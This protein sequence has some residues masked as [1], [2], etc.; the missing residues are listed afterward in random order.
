MAMIRR[1]GS[2]LAIVAAL[3]AP[4]NGQDYFARLGGPFSRVLVLNAPF[5]AEATTRVREVSP[6]GTARLHTVTA[7]YYRDSQGQV[8]AEVDTPWGPY[9]VVASQGPERVEFYA[10]DQTK[11]TYRIAAYG[12]AAL[13]F[14]GEGGVA[15]P[16]GK[17]CF[18]YPPRVAAGVSD[19]ERLR[20][21]NAQ[22]SP[23][24]GIVTASHRSDEIPS[25]D[26]KAT[27]IRRS[28]D[29]ELTNIRR[30]E[31]PAKLF[32]VPPDYTFVSIGSRED[33]VVGFAPWQSPPACKPQKR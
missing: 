5:S 17:V 19:A 28:V 30:E 13:L 2:L 23:D 10:L 20:A 31:P 29:Y 18:Q 14:N 16:V 4:A 15:L 24:L 11:R 21:V 32:Q 27:N 9:V 12:I 22:V 6:D 1:T 8:R 25:V 3:A 33:P 26:S 7:R